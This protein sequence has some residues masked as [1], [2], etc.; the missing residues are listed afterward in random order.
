MADR[1]H[2][3]TVAGAYAKIESHEQ[4]CADRYANIYAMLKAIL[5]ALGMMFL[6]LL[7]WAL[8]QVYTLQPLREHQQPVTVQ[9][10]QKQ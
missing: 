3:M 7:G 1:E 6:G 9:M 10:N 4:L 8:I 2:P 5:G